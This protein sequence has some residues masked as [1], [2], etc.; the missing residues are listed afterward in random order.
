[1]SQVAQSLVMDVLPWPQGRG[2]SGATAWW[3]YVLSKEEKH[4]LDNLLGIALLDGDFCD[5]LVNKRDETLLS[6]FGFSE[7]TRTWLRKIKANTLHE[8]AQAIMSGP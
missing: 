2:F 4:R 7:E 3:D 8:L 5:R 6:E 1:M